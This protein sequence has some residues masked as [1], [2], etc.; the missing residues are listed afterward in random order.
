MNEIDIENSKCPE[1]K[2]SN[3][4][5]VLAYLIQKADQRNLQKLYKGFPE[6]VVMVCKYWGNDYKL[7]GLV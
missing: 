4:N 5:C 1:T 7:K 3:F 6:E 2:A